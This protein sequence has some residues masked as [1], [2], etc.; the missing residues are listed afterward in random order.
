[1]ILFSGE[2]EQEASLGVMAEV[3]TGEKGRREVGKIQ[4]LGR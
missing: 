3:G 2:R 1:M 4:E